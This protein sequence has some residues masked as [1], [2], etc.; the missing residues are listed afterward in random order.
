MSAPYNRRMGACLQCSQRKRKCDHKHPRCSQC[1]KRGQICEPKTFR[2]FTPSAFNTARWTEGL[3]GSSLASEPNRDGETELSHAQRTPLST[4]DTPVPTPD[5]HQKDL[6]EAGHDLCETPI[7]PSA[8]SYFT[9][10]HPSQAT[11]HTSSPPGLGHIP[12]AWY[13][14][15][16]SITAFL[17]ELHDSA[18]DTSNEGNI[19]PNGMA[20][21]IPEF[22]P[23]EVSP[24]QLYCPMPWPD[25]MLAS[26][27]RRFLWQYFLSAAE[28][29]FLCLDWEDV[30]HLYAYQHPY[31]TNLPHMALSNAA[32]RGAI[33]CFSAAQYQLRFEREDFI[34]T[35]SVTC[36]EAVRSMELQLS[37]TTRDE[38]NLLSIVYAATLLYS[39]GPER[40]D[41]LRI[42]SQL[43]IEFLARWKP[44]TN[45]SKSYP[46]IT[47]T[48]Y[49]WTVIST[50]CSLQKPNPALG[51]RICHMIEMGDDEIE[52]KY[53][54]AF[55]SW[56]SHPIYT[57]SPRLV[58]PLLRIGRLL[59]SQLS[60]LDAG[61]DHEPPPT[62][63]SRVVEAEEILLQ[64][65]ERDA[66]VSESA[67]DG[68]DPVAVVALNESMYAASSILL[69][70]RI[71][72]LAFT[73]PFIRRQ[74]R[75]VVD[76]ISKI[77]P[78]SHVSYAIVFPLFIAGCE[79]VEPQVRDVVKQRLREPRG[80]SYNRGDVIGALHH[81][82]RITP[83]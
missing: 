26:P 31:V 38:S 61:A 13:D 54:N 15:S 70:A 17:S 42:A 77:Q 56:V 24:S 14:N 57:F 3:L 39:F 11:N 83:G 59:Q 19:T 9:L 45:A 21:A 62:W 66:N 60:Q 6:T 37:S 2:S 65:R 1:L 58:N 5:G 40:R 44:E 49:R 41:Y 47:L 22:F 80:V 52:Q 72:G 34:V 78:T 36:S 25:D 74:T 43:V 82:I 68:A 76:E 33:L 73:A 67:L 48:E 51:D 35:K 12:D 20:V 64:A 16:I 71:H 7:R 8:Y 18:K 81:A 30:G 79:A 27:E 10:G 55:Q 32:L 28:T 50:L 46:E 69:Y 53:S 63:E 23:L 4:L 29:D 75:I